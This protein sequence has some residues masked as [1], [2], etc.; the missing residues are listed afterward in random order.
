MYETAS[1]RG[2]LTALM[3]AGYGSPG[4]ELPSP[5]NKRD[6]DLLLSDETLVTARRVSAQMHARGYILAQDTGLA[7]GEMQMCVDVNNSMCQAA[8]GYFYEYGI[9]G[10]K[11]AT[12]AL[13]LYQA[14]ADQGNMYGQF[15]LGFLYDTGDGVPKDA[16]KAL[17]YYRAAAAQGHLTAKNRLTQL[18]Q[19][20]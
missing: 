10:T 16:A 19:P 12:K 3:L 11:D 14:S 9:T 8:M 13:P 6:L 15:W 2:D 1:I 20:L 18:G 7:Q 17:Q 4:T 5:R